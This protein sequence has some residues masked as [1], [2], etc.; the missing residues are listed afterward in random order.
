[1]VINIP[2]ELLLI[3]FILIFSI[4]VFRKG[5]L[6]KKGRKDVILPPYKIIRFIYRIFV[7][8]DRANQIIARFMQS[9]RYK[10]MAHSYIVGGIWF[11]FIDLLLIVIVILKFKNGQ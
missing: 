3:P 5:L 7:G 6:V 9:D 8:S 11:F 2:V 1:M 10:E 4:D